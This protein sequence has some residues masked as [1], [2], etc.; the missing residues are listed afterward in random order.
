MK[1]QRKNLP[2]L[3]VGTLVFF[4][5]NKGIARGK[6]VHASDPQQF[7]YT[8][9][10]NGYRFAGKAVDRQHVPVI[11][12]HIWAMDELEDLAERLLHE[13]EVAKRTLASVRK[14][15]EEAGNPIPDPPAADELEPRTMAEI[16]RTAVAQA[17]QRCGGDKPLAAKQLGVSVKTIYNWLPKA[18]AAKR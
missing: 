7:H 12:L 9:A 10:T 13:I 3:A 6:I 8:I 15:A 2:P 14:S 11:R 1:K 5:R 4:L 16:Q 18:E 17:L